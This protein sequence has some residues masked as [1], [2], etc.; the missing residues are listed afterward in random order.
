M[1]TCARGGRPPPFR[2]DRSGH[3]Q[4]LTDRLRLRPALGED[5]HALEPRLVEQ[6]GEP[7]CSW[8]EGRMHDEWRWSAATEFPPFD[9]VD[10]RRQWLA[11]EERRTGEVIGLAELLVPAP[12][13]AP[14]IGLIVIEPN[15]RNAGLGG[16][17]VAAIER[18]LAPG[19][20]ELRLNVALANTGARRFWERHGYHEI[21]D[22]WRR[23]DGLPAKSLV[24]SKR[25]V[26]PLLPTRAR[27]PEASSPVGASARPRASG[28]PHV[29]GRSLGLVADLV[30]RRQRSDSAARPT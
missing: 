2:I 18:S 6:R 19:W 13:G 12:D 7:G 22:A 16:E 8:G 27:P 3:R 21:P 20:V 11:I 23:Y 4:L 30:Y 10:M 1:D 28:Q 17:A 5:F 15:R 9:A 14:W 26:A 24:L 29:T 25:L